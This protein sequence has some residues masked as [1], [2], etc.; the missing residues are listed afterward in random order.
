[1]QCVTLHTCIHVYIFVL[2]YSF[3]SVWCLF[4]LM[5]MWGCTVCCVLRQVKD[6]NLFQQIFLDLKHFLC[7]SHRFLRGRKKTFYFWITHQS[8][9]LLLWQQTFYAKW[10]KSLCF[11]TAVSPHAKCTSCR[12]VSGWAAS[13]Q[14]DSS[15]SGR[16]TQTSVDTS[17]D[18]N[19]DAFL[20][21]KSSSI[22][23]FNRGYVAFLC[24]L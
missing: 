3:T 11:N 19:G 14:P 12:R 16:R 7:I 22:V 20:R 18:T 15:N 17:L 1:M 23:A 5:D 6:D 10:W 24:M 9:Q 21:K 2:S 8:V 4:C 13:F